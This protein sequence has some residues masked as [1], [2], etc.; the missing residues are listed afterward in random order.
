[1]HE[2]LYLCTEPELTS[3]NGT[4]NYV[5]EAPKGRDAKRFRVFSGSNDEVRFWD[6]SVHAKRDVWDVGRGIVGPCESWV[7]CLAG[8]ESR[9]R[10]AADSKNGDVFI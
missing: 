7:W 2:C 3:H 8:S 10:V 9:T 5:T 4:V 1:M 6:V